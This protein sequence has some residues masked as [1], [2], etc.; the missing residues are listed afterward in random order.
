MTGDLDDPVSAALGTRHQALDRTVSRL[1]SVN[2]LAVL[3][4]GYAMVTE[5][6]TRAVIKS[7]DQAL[8]DAE[9]DVRLSDGRLRCTVRDKQADD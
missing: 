1:H 2:P 8:V 5:P 3:A 9:V 4:R 7:I 6:Q